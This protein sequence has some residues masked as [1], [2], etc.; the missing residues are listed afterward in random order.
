MGFLASS[1]NDIRPTIIKKTGVDMSKGKIA[2]QK[3]SQGHLKA[4]KDEV[5]ELIE[6]RNPC[7]RGCD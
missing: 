3:A 7:K 2:Q 1:Y 4:S 5:D 6:Q